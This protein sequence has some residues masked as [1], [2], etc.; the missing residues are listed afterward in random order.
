MP[1]ER[2]MDRQTAFALRR[3]ERS[4]NEPLIRGIPGGTR[5]DPPPSRHRHSSFLP[6]QEFLKMQ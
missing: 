5:A 1:R 6:F 4:A 3:A 2:V